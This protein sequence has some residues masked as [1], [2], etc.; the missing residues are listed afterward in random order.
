MPVGLQ[1]F[2]ADIID[3]LVQG[4]PGKSVCHG[5]LG[6]STVALVRGRDRVILIDAGSFNMR[7]LVDAQLRSRGLGVE[8]VTDVLL[9]HSHYDHSMNWPM[10]PRARIVIGSEELAWAAAQPVGDLLVPEFYI[11][12]LAAWPQL[13]VV[14]DGEEAAPGI[15]AYDSAGHT[16]GHL[17]FYLTSADRDV[18]FTGDAAKNRT[19]LVGRRTDMTMD[20]GASLATL[21]RI[22]KLWRRRP[23]TILV[24]G[25]DVPMVLD[26]GVPRYIEGRR[27]GIAAWFGDTLETTTLFELTA[28]A[29]PRPVRTA[30][31]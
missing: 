12:E 8:D 21:D 27:A 26:G 10:F 9:T 2:E 6:W 15:I 28:D 24:P 25:H 14:R 7:R 31:E 17:M 16:P 11:R 18:L 4:F 1:D 3:I 19:E 13:R 23:G 22:W 29:A 30:A 20:E 5:G